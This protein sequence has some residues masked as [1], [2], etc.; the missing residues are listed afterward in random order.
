MLITTVKKYH[1]SL[2]AICV[3]GPMLNIFT[4]RIFEWFIVR[5]ELLSLAS[6]SSLIFVGKARSLPS[7]EYLKSISI[8]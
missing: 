6:L 1:T 7:V 4:A 2:G 3:Q 8:K 5:K